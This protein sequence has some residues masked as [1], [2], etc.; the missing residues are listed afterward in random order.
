M[1]QMQL[2]RQDTKEEEAMQKK[3]PE[4][5]IKDLLSLCMLSNMCIAKTSK[6]MAKNDWA[7]NWME[8]PKMA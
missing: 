1:R 8:T 4:I 3:V 5:C 6:D 2:E 7:G